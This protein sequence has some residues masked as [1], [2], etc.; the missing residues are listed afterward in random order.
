MERNN[1]FKLLE[2]NYKSFESNLFRIDELFQKRYMI[3]Q[4]FGQKNY[5]KK[6]CATTLLL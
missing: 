2:Q 4:N 6:F 5:I 3:E 1:I